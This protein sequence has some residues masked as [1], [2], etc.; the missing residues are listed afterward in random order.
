M[1]DERPNP[2]ALLADL[3]REAAAGRRGRLKVFLGMCPG[4]GK[5]Y[6][7]LGS[8]AEQVVRHSPCPVLVI[9]AQG[10]QSAKSE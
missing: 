3:Q 10:A 7:M 9:R 6:A 1:T 2:D 4:V 5:T 8:E